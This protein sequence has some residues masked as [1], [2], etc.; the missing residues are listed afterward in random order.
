L[1]G[2]A[3]ATAISVF[4]AF[5]LLI[6][7]HLKNSDIKKLQETVNYAQRHD[8]VTKALNG[9]ALPLLSS[10]TST[11]ANESPRTPAV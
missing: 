7:L 3:G 11:A 1:V 5:P 4:V 8:S 9:A 6:S 10:T 2:F